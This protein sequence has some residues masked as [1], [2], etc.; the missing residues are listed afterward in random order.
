MDSTKKSPFVVTTVVE[1]G[2]GL[3]LMILPSVAVLFL[4]G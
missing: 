2:A 4:L 3:A 1:L